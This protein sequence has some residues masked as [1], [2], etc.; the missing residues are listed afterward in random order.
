M[1]RSSAYER[2]SPNRISPID[3][4]HAAFDSLETQWD[5]SFKL[6]DRGTT[7]YADSAV[8]TLS[9]TNVPEPATGVLLIVGAI[10]LRRR[11]GA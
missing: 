10:T 1:K 11:Q 4:D 8:F 7:L 3:A 5:V 9:F 2:P 6:V